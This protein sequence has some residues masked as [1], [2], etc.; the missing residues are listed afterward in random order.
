MTDGDS[1]NWYF[2][3]LETG[4]KLSMLLLGFVIVIFSLSFWFVGIKMLYSST[5]LS[6]T[7]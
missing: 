5:F 7:S 3:L 6:Q 4:S 2:R 1:G